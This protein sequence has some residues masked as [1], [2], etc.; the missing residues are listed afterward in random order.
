MAAVLDDVDRRLV[1]ALRA[2]GRASMRSLAQA[3]HI[4]RANVYN[5]VDRLE[6][7]G[8]ISGYTAVV[9]PQQLG[10][11]IA[12]YVYLDVAQQSWQTLQQK[13]LDIPEVAGGALV[14]GE[15]DI[16]LLVRTADAAA[17]RE[18]VLTK[19][20]NMPEVLSTQTVLIFDEL[21][22]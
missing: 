15:H 10:L 20:Q 3:L 6:R 5:R 11:G 14:S 16:V 22:R 19:L 4:S 2:D 21:T 18:L 7:D 9:D 8:V 12:A 1:D 13:V 17:L